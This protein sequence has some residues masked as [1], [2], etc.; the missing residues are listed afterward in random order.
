MNQ[1]SV[2]TPVKIVRSVFVPNLLM[3]STTLANSL[4]TFVVQFSLLNLDFSHEVY[5]L[6]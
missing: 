5:W 4:H 2:E 3:G 1:P 6:E